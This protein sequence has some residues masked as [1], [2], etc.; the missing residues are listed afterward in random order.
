MKKYIY[1][2]IAVLALNST[3]VFAEEPSKD[4]YWGFSGASNFLANP[5]INWQLFD[6]EEKYDIGYNVNVF[7]GYRFA[8]SWRIEAEGGYR[9]NKLKESRV[10]DSPTVSV[11][12]GKLES[13]HLLFNLYC[14]WKFKSAFSPYV[15]IGIGYCRVDYQNKT[16]GY[17]SVGSSSDSAASQAI[18]GLNYEWTDWMSLFCDLKYFSCIDPKMNDE[19]GSRVEAEYSNQSI[20]IGL[21][22]AW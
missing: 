17:P 20:N 2:F 9:K 19:T 7:S 5:V 1:L 12:D 3:N 18:L 21:K 15:G 22:L 16:A 14:D 6:S 13:M 4:Y 10:K 8:K 11:G